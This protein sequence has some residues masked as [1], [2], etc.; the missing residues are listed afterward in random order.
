MARADALVHHDAE[1]HD[2][3]VVFAGEE[4]GDGL[5][6][7]DEHA[8]RAELVAV[9]VDGLRVDAGEVGD[10]EARMEWA[11][12]NDEARQQAQAVEELDEADQE[13]RQHRQREHEVRKAVGVVVMLLF[14]VERD[15]VLDLAV[16]GNDV[17]P[18]LKEDLHAR[19]VGRAVGARFENDEADAEMVALVYLRVHDE[20]VDLRVLLIRL[21]V[22][23]ED[24]RHVGDAHA[25]PPLAL[26]VAAHRLHLGVLGDVVVRVIAARHDIGKR[27]NNGAGILDSGSVRTHGNTFFH[28]SSR[29]FYTFLTQYAMF[30][31]LRLSY[32]FFKTA[33]PLCFFKPKRKNLTF[34]LVDKKSFRSFLFFY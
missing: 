8:R 5:A 22:G 28:G 25:L 3:L 4:V 10:E 33:A 31:F 29:I 20:A 15:R 26:D 32:I 13:R 7:A 6:H 19:L 9:V 24:Q 18:V 23:G 12:V 30:F 21:E 11:E 34:C 16:D 17:V 2:L 14:L 1:R 27:R